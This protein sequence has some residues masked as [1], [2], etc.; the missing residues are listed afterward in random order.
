M[1][2]HGA[3]PRISAGLT[4][5]PAADGG[6]AQLQQLRPL[7]RHSSDE[8][9]QRARPTTT[10][11]AA[12]AK[13]AAESELDGVRGSAP[14][15]VAKEPIIPKGLS[16]A[17]HPA[18]TSACT[19][20]AARGAAAAAAG[21]RAH[22]TILLDVMYRVSPLLMKQQ[23]ASTAEQHQRHLAAACEAGVA[24][25]VPQ[26]TS[27]APGVGIDPLHPGIFEC[28][29]TTHMLEVKRAVSRAMH[30]QHAST[31]RRT[32]G[33]TVDPRQSLWHRPDDGLPRA[34]DPA[35]M[36]AEYQR[37][38]GCKVVPGR[39]QHTCS[40]SRKY[41]V[42]QC[43]HNRT[44]I[45]C[46][47][48]SAA[49]L[50]TC[51][52][53]TEVGSWEP[54]SDPECYGAY[55]IDA[56]KCGFDPVF[57]S[58]PVPSF[59][60]NHRPTYDDYEASVK[61][62]QKVEAFDVFSE[63]QFERPFMTSPLL[64]VVRP[65]HRRDA[66]ATGSIPKARVAID[67]SSSGINDCLAPWRF[68]YEGV[69]AAVRLVRPG[70]WMGKTDLRSYF[71]FLPA[72][73]PFQRFLGFSDPR[74]EAGQHW[75]GSAAPTAAWTASR[76]RRRVGRY[77]R[78]ITCPF[79][80]SVLPAFASFISGEL[81]RY[82]RS[83]GVRRC[84]MMIDDLFL[85]ASTKEECAAQ[86][87]LVSGLFS[88]L[89]LAPAPEKAE[90]PAQKLDFLGA[91]ID[92]VAGM[93]DVNHDRLEV[94]GDELYDMLAA[95]AVTRDQVLSTAGKLSWMALF[96]ANTRTW[97]RRIW[98]F[99]RDTPDVPDDVKLSSGAA[100]D[101]RWWL[102][103][104]AA[105]GVDRAT[106]RGG[107]SP[108]TAAQTSEVLAR[109]TLDELQRLCRFSGVGV[110]G[111]ASRMAPLL[112]AWRCKEHRGGG[113]RGSAIF[114]GASV[115]EL[116]SLRD[117]IDGE[118]AQARHDASVARGESAFGVGDGDEPAPRLERTAQIVELAAGVGGFHIGSRTVP[119]TH[120]AMAIEGCPTARSVY[121]EAHG[122]RPLGVDMTDVEAVVAAVRG[123]SVDSDDM[124]LFASPP[125]QPWSRAGTHTASDPRADVLAAVIDT[126]LR[127]RPLKLIIENVPEMLYSDVY[128]DNAKRLSAVG[129]VVESA[130]V[131][132]EHLGVPQRRRRAIVV[133]SRDGVPVRLAAAAARA[134]AG[135][136][137]TVQQI[138]PQVDFFYHRHRQN[139]G[140][141]VYDAAAY[142]SPPLRTN[143]TS[144]PR[145]ATYQRRRNDD[146]DFGRCV[147][148][149]V[150]QLAEVQ[151]FPARFPWPPRSFRCKC[152]FCT[153][154]GVSSASR[155]LGNA[156][157]PAVAAFALRVA[158]HGDGAGRHSAAD[159][160]GT[161]GVAPADGA[162]AA[163]SAA[164]GEPVGVRAQHLPGLTSMINMKSDAAGDAR[165]CFFV[166]RPGGEHDIVWTQ[167]MGSDA[168]VHVPFYELSAVALAFEMF[169]HE[170]RG[171]L[172]RLGIDS[173]PV[174]AML[175]SGSSRD[176][177][178]M[179]LLRAMSTASFVYDVDWVATHVTRSRNALSDQGTR[180]RSPQDFEPYLRAEGFGGLEPGATASSCP[181][182]SLLQ[183]GRT[184]RLRLGR[185]RRS[186]GRS[187][188]SSTAARW[189][190][191]GA[192]S[193]RRTTETT[194]TLAHG[195]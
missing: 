133:A 146:A 193:A 7:R 48:A 176:P 13:A 123:M 64:T 161:T 156:I 53:A 23:A 2:L 20:A 98:D 102:R 61:H 80:V 163:R 34:G 97:L 37:S 124:I 63:P 25:A 184:Q 140:K 69:D 84:T 142:P 46:R 73:E 128:L 177:D 72:S 14:E 29:F 40:V 187:R 100:D 55:L 160:R 88:A 159:G 141:C 41:R 171:C 38:S 101:M 89:G 134:S 24:A 185:R 108:A 32:D 16:A 114:D 33:T 83:F 30:T 126:A 52:S 58:K 96:L 4:K 125:C 66:A 18:A 77:R 27:P 86:M 150:E 192:H 191:S 153:K 1:G 103:R 85:A 151:G 164:A 137:C 190:S 111:G 81:T 57:E 51:T 47:L 45:Q 182:S 167:L 129:Y 68:K 8:A 91:D 79:G 5:G 59:R 90:G 105:N 115:S 113:F 92:T 42:W 157:C 175:S 15:C 93:V 149:D 17:L 78:Y 143:C 139:G 168:Q 43:L 74:L 110:G 148:F 130:I 75:H 118:L 117:M 136:A 21:A 183:S 99:V 154:S 172:V 12:A 11:A 56:I 131:S 169:A 147:V 106:G 82:A 188:A 189:R 109:L 35:A 158:L 112:A 31:T 155:Q 71:L 28:G 22:V 54:T 174:V 186:P 122:L 60:P 6:A 62:L 87:A 95:D 116:D 178:L 181:T 3:A 195:A 120:V 67:M 127:L 180:C 173:A 107:L 49:Q 194:A 132:P 26:P 162:A 121:Q 19:A 165:V 179:R 166:D 76:P 70:D 152:A 138:F 39:P 65:K 36:Y 119:G 104:V 94:V 9:V 10:P 44:C 50:V 145:A 170:W 144:A 135:R